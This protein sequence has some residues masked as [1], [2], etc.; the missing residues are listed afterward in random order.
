MGVTSGVPAARRLLALVSAIAV[1]GLTLAA[2]SSSTTNSASSSSTTSSNG[3]SSSTTNGAGSGS[4]TTA[5]ST[6]SQ[7][8]KFES[9]VQSATGGTFK[10]TYAE[11][12]SAAGSQNSTLTFEQLPPKYLF[13]S[14][15]TG[16]ADVI[17]TGTAT[18]VCSGTSGHAYCVSYSSSAD[19]FAGL[20][21][22]I[23][24]K[25]VLTTLHSVQTGLASK[26]AGVQA[27]FSSQMFA[28][29]PSK[30]VSGTYQ[31]NSFKYCVT[32]SGVLAYAGGSQAKTFGSISLTSYSTSVSA[33]DFALPAGATVVTLPST[34]TTS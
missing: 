4:S 32:D 25:S 8:A 28:G 14:G 5:A 15:G 13:S 18:Y 29:Q 6:A 19:P 1:T 22:V 3:S 34:S 9:S 7:L 30:C 12:S 33:S 27:S 10:L 24:G 2:C 16:A 20:L 11:T 21:N 17:D 31:G 26:L 23:S